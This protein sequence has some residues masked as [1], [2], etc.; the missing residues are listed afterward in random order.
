[1]EV[2][3]AAF[4]YVASQLRPGLSRPRF[5]EE[6]HDLWFTRYT[7]FYEFPPIHHCSGFEHV[8]VGEGRYR[9]RSD[10]GEVT[11]YHSWVK[12]H[13]DEAA[14]LVNFRGHKYDLQGGQDPDDPRVASLQMSW[15]HRE[16]H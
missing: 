2:M 1:T 11:G 15:T 3:D 13:L 16:R 5:C 6:L 10:Q 12:F 9:R 7:N 4:D 14:G 8:F